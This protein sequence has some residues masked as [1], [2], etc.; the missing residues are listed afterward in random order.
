MPT[1]IVSVGVII[2]SRSGNFPFFLARA[3]PWRGFSFVQS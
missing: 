2:A 1:L 3:L